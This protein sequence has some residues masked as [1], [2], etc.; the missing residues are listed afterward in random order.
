MTVIY[1]ILM[2]SILCIPNTWAQD[3]LQHKYLTIE[4]EENESIHNLI[5]KGHSSVEHSKKKS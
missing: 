1:N 2:I 3:S 4:T 5:L